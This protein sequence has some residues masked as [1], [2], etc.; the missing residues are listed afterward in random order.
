MGASGMSTAT[1]PPAG[2][3]IRGISVRQPHVACILAGDKTI[4]NRPRATLMGS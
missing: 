1:L 4:E 3:W 2:D